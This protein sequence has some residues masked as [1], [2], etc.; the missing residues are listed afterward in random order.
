MKPALHIVGLPHTQTTADYAT[1]AYTQKIVK[2]CRMLHGGDRQVFLYAGE[3]ND[4]PCDE[5]VVCVTDAEREAWFGAHN[6]GDLGRG[7]FD[8]N[9]GSPWWQAMNARA[10][11]AIRQ[12]CDDHDLLLLIAGRSQQQIA[13]A[14]PH[15]IVAEWGVGYEGIIT[16]KTGSPAFCAW[17]SYWHQAFVYGTLGWRFPERYGFDCVVP[18]FFDPDEFPHVN[19]GDGDYLLFVGRLIQHKGAHIAAQ[20]AAELNMPLV[21]AGPGAIDQGDD[22]VQAAEIRIEPCTYV[23]P[24]G[25]EERAKLMA[26]AAALLAPTTYL[27]PFGGV[28]VEAMMC[29]T[30]AVTFDA[31]AFVETVQPA[32]S[33]YRFHTFHEGVQ[34]TRQA[35][36]LNNDAVR[37][38]ALS[39]YSLDAVRPL[40]EAWFDRLDGLWH[41]GWYAKPESV[42][43][44]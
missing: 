39:R 4:A 36:E 26:G 16:G 8:W 5:H 32:V 24:V 33:G 13:D 15:L 38:Y 19:H 10:A 2:L 31:G 35:M 1:C 25:I 29:G 11:D 18:N 3:H 6:E 17:E 27:E 34:A 41:D 40:Y 23:G 14:L 12:R 37:D 9:P 20:I 42:A 21:V 43:C 30:P 22:W 28:A 44:V 7:G